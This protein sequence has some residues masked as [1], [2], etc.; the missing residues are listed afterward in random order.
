[1]TLTLLSILISTKL[2]LTNGENDDH[3]H[4]N[5]QGKD[6]IFVCLFFVMYWKCIFITT[7]HAQTPA[8]LRVILVV[9]TQGM[10]CLIDLVWFGLVF[11]ETGF[12]R[13]TAQV[14]L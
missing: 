6:T 1:M 12:L 8:Y 10:G 9:M 4:R 2:N 11:L 7:T 3:F 13:V 14:V 5:L